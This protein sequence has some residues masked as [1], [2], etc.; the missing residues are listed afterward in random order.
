MFII[1][2]IVVWLGSDGPSRFMF[3]RSRFHFFPMLFG[4]TLAHEFHISYSHNEWYLLFS[5]ND[6]IE[7]VKESPVKTNYNNNNNI[8]II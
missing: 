6:M 4:K 2:I 7:M 3:F 1:I 8:I 5:R